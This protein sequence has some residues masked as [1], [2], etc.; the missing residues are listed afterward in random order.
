MQ[1]RMYGK[2]ND[3]IVRDFLGPDLTADEVRE[4]GAAKERLYRELMAGAIDGFAG[5][6]SAGIPRPYAGPPRGGHQ[7]GTRKCELRLDAR[8]PEAILSGDRRRPSGAEARSRIRKSI[9]ERRNSRCPACDCIVFEDSLPGLEA[10]RNA[11]MRT[12]GVKTTHAELP[13]ADLAIDNFLSVE[14]DPWLR[15]QMPR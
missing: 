15:L 14:L 13:E 1:Q 5:A 9:C 4:H 7:R 2:R 10:A 6:G 8:R 12:V 11:D 3:E